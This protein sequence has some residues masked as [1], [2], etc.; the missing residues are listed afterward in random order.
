MSTRT[1]YHAS[2]SR[3]VG[4]TLLPL[5]AMADREDFRSLYTERLERYRKREDLLN[6][7]IPPLDCAWRDVVFLSAISPS[8]VFDR[9]ASILENVKPMDMSLFLEVRG[10]YQAFCIELSEL[11]RSRL[12]AYFPSN[13]YPK[14]ED[15]LPFSEELW[16]R[17]VYFPPW[18]ESYYREVFAS[19]QR[20]L[21]WNGLPHILYKGEI[22]I[23]RGKIMNV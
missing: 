14:Q 3:L 9:V 6:V 13:E 7:R 1:L 8:E 4:D 5:S 2:R 23:D 19:G 21:Y 20:P 16:D 22:P 12:A 17:L 15:F 10:K 18:T 11:D